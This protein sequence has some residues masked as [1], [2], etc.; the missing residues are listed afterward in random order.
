MTA[1]AIRKIK[2][3]ERSRN[4]NKARGKAEYFIGIKAVPGAL[5]YI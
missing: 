1:S 2:H 4:T 5:F 3:E